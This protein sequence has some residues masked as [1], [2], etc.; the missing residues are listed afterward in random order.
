MGTIADELDSID[1]NFS[2][3]A[4]RLPVL[5]LSYI[6]SQPT[7]AELR[8][9]AVAQLEGRSC[10]GTNQS[11]N[12]WSVRGQYDERLG[13]VANILLQEATSFG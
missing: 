2:H 8:A 3:Y 13:L 1:W 7:Q 12:H 5:K 6:G 10:S 11:E 9:K 4:K